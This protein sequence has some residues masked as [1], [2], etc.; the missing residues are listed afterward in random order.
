MDGITILRRC[1][2]YGEDV[3]GLHERI[4]RRRSLANRMTASYR[5]TGGGHGG[6][7][8]DRMAAM[9]ADLEQIEAQLKHRDERY[10]AERI[11]AV[12]LMDIVDVREARVLELYYI[13]AMT[14]EGA[15]GAIGFSVQHARRLR[16]SAEGKIL[17]A[18][19]VSSMLPAW[20]TDEG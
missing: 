18:G 9:V 13:E 2:R 8:T 20:Y 5:Q 6:A 3:E 1:R 15:A 17:D 19:D 7:E 14:M 12:E 16:K 10:N 11:A 4:E